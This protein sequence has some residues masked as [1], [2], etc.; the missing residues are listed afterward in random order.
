MKPPEDLV[1]EP[2]QTVVTL[3]LPAVRALSLAVA[4]TLAKGLFAVNFKLTKQVPT[5]V[6]RPS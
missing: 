1:P 2:M 6:R 5:V 3:R 4:A